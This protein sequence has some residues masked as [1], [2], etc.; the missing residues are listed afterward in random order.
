MVMIQFY[1]L[2]SQQ[3]PGDLQKINISSIVYHTYSFFIVAYIYLQ[4]F[5]SQKEKEQG[6][7]LFHVSKSK[8]R[9]PTARRLHNSK[10]KYYED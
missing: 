4:Q 6:N 3:H 7:V 5:D 8:F 2:I 10:G 1:I 9:S